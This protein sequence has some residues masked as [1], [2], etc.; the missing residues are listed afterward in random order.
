[1][2]IAAD[3]YEY[4]DAWEKFNDT[5]FPEK[6]DS[7]SNLSV[8][9]IADSDYNHAK[10]V[11]N[12]FEIKHLAEYHDLYLKNN[13]LL[14]ADVFK[15]FRKM[16]LEIC[17]LDPAKFISAGLPWKEA[18]KRTKVELELLTDSFMLLIVQK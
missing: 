14:L 9:D 3:P 11:C 13:T 18:L 12:Y 2:F 4:L 5:S 15:N 6:H 7:S 16:C 10:R 1:M 8:E 17:Q